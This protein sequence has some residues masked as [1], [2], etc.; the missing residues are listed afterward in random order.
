MIGDEVDGQ[1][2]A[3]LCNHFLQREN[4]EEARNLRIIGRRKAREEGDL[5][6]FRVR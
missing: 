1:F 5:G 6:I 3:E 2:D 4:G